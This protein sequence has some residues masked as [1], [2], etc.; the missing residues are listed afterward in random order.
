M[1]RKT[2]FR[3]A[4]T[5]VALA[6]LAGAS[7]A[8]AA[9]VTYRNT[10]SNNAA[11]CDGSAPAVWVTINGVKASTGKIRVQ[12]YRGVASDWLE[13]GKWIYRI[14]A[15]ARAGQMTICMP[16][17]T[18][19]TYGIAVRHDVNGNGSTDLSSDG[20]GM[21]NNPSINIFNLGKPSYKKTAFSVGDTVKSIT[22]SMRYM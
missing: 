2:A 12:L 15:P 11:Q 5:S 8:V 18:A 22:I 16:V 6:A 1:T 19:G 7:L 21:S 13:T 10:I 4:A 20:G 17:P 14:E 9:P 3:F